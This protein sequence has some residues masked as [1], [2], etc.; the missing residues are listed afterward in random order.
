MVTTL[1]PTETIKFCTELM[2]EANFVVVTTID[3]EGFPESRAMF[4]LKNSTKFPTLKPIVNSKDD[5]FYTILGTNTSSNKIQEIKHNPKATL[6]YC[7]PEKFHGLTLTGVLQFR[8]EM[9]LK[10]DLWVDGW[11][12]YYPQGYKDPDYTILQL[13]PQYARGWYGSGKYEFKISYENKQISYD[14]L[15]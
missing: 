6:Y 1:N 9:D 8:E 15:Q 2:N 3:T 4:N 12:I 5:P 7:V 14:F 10:K 13:I 11:E